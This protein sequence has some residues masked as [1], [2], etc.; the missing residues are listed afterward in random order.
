MFLNVFRL[1]GMNRAENFFHELFGVGNVE[2]VFAV[3][4]NANHTEI[5]ITHHN[6]I[7]S[8]PLHL[9][10][11]AQIDKVNVYLFGVFKCVFPVCNCGENGR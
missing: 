5:L 4:R 7:R 11:S 8:A 6:G 9:R 3:A 2:R 1:V 10:K